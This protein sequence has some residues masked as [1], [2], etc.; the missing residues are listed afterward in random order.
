MAQA[1][2]TAPKA[3]GKDQ[4]K[5]GAVRCGQVEWLKEVS[6]EHVE[7]CADSLLT[8]CLQLWLI[9]HH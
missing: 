5:L 8:G 1:L 4:E 3:S 9:G 2:K 6:L 7:A